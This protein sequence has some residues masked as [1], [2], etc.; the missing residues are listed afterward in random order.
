MR[1]GVHVSIGGGLRKAV[2]SAVAIGCNALQ[3]FSSNPMGWRIA[4][5]DPQAAAEF[6]AL[7]RAHDLQPVVLHT[8]YLINL[9]SDDPAILSKSRA[10]VR[11]ALDRAAVLGARYVV[12]HIGSHKGRGMEVG[13][14][15]VVDSLAAILRPGDEPVLLLENTPGSGNEIGGAFGELATILA[16]LPAHRAHLGVCL[17]TAHLWGAGHDLSTPEGVTAT[18]DEFQRVVGLDRLPVIHANDSSVRRGSRN[19]VHEPPGHGLIGGE[20]FRTLLND[21]RLAA[22]TF[23]LEMPRVEVIAESRARLAELRGLVV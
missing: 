3:I 20:G 16:A 5:L 18:I 14:A 9:A 15:A 11:A 17:D 8:P 10:T 6:A 13:I 22:L 1:L 2:A 12:T 4:P 19:D 23:I 7:T 21:P